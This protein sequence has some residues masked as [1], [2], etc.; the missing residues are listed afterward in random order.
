MCR[1]SDLWDITPSE[2]L[3]RI[4]RMDGNSFDYKPGQFMQVSILGAG[5]APIFIS[6][7]PTRS[8]N[9]DL[10]IRKADVLTKMMH[11]LKSDDNLGLRGPFGTFFD[12]ESFKGKDLLLITGVCGLAPMK[13]LI[14]YVEDCR[15]DFG[16]ANILYGAKSH[17]DLLYKRELVNWQ[18]SDRLN[19]GVTVDNVPTG[20]CWDGR[21]GL[22]PSLVQSLKIEP[23]R[24]EAV[25][26]MEYCLDA[27]FV[28]TTQHYGQSPVILNL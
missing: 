4:E 10:T 5:E 15:D 8:Q 19:C 2:K 28:D 23:S 26:A 6:S 25:K 12:A 3:F 24:T 17:Q 20:N 22:I 9:M 11:L 13:S 1:I 21:A 7:S 14:Q 18:H 27:A 16:N